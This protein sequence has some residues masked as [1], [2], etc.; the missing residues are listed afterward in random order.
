[1]KKRETTDHDDCNARAVMMT[2]VFFL[3][4]MPRHVKTFVFLGFINADF[5]VLVA[6]TWTSLVAHILYT[7]NS[8]INFFVYVMAG[9]KFRGDLAKVFKPGGI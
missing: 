7:V 9:S 5:D 6:Y 3:L 4:T 1:M 8:A 2:I